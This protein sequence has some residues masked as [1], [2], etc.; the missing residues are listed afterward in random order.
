MKKL[1]IP[2]LAF[3]AGMIFGST[4][5]GEKLVQKIKFWEKR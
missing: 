1:L 4:D 5:Q 3:V 2:V